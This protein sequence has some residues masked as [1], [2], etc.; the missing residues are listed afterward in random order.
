MMTRAKSCPIVPR[1]GQSDRDDKG[2]DGFRGAGTTGATYLPSGY[3]FFTCLVGKSKTITGNTSILALVTHCTDAALSGS[4]VP[5]TRWIIN[6][7]T[8]FFQEKQ[9]SGLLYN[10]L[11]LVF[12]VILS[13]EKS[14]GWEYVRT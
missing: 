2:K 3:M 6:I 13:K 4:R 1:N 10:E 14:K 5:A 7:P 8:Q 12:T 11:N 9:F